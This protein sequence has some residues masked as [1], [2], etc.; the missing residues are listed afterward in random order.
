MREWTFAQRE[1][2]EELALLHF[3]S[4][5]KR[6]P[7]GEVEFHITVKEFASPQQQAMQFFA[8]ADKQTNQKTQPYT[9]CGWGTT[10]L[11]ALTACVQAIHRFP[12]KGPEVA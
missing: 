7:S 12:Y 11:A 3:F 5:K 2:S 1:D 10:L 8:M 6:Q 9:P 4:I